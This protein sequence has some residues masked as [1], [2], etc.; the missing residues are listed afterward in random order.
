MTTLETIQIGRIRT[1]H[2]VT[3][4]KLAS[5]NIVSNPR[6]DHCGNTEDLAH[7]LYDCP[8]YDTHREK[9]QILY[10]NKPIIKIIQDSN[11]REYKQIV[12]YLN[13]INKNVW[14]YVK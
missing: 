5:W 2:V 7:I 11:P 1:G 8:K 14:V 6:C 10:N 9:I 13:E 3:K 12:E 4:E